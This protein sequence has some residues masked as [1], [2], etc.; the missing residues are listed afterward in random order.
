MCCED[1]SLLHEGLPQGTNALRWH[2]PLA[3]SSESWYNGGSSFP[4]L[5]SQSVRKWTGDIIFLLTVAAAVAGWMYLYPRPSN[6]PLSALQTPS[7]LQTATLLTYASSEGTKLAYRLYQPR[8]GDVDSVL[9]LLHDTLLHS[10]WYSNLGQQLAERGVAVYLPDRRG[11]GHSAGNRQDASENRDVLTDDVTALIAVAQARYP[12]KQVFLAGHGRGAGLAV[13]YVASQRPV[14]GVI[15]I[16]PYI[17]DGQPNLRPAGWR[18]LVAAHPGEA[19]LARAGLIDWRIWR[20]NWPPAMRAADPLIE[21][22][23]SIAWQQQT[24]PDDLEAAFRTLASPLLCLQGQSDPMFDAAETSEFV[25][26]FAAPDRT[27]QLM[28]GVD[29]LTIIDAAAP[30]IADWLVER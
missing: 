30:A 22:R 11:W 14:A 26:R 21:T 9:I 19:F 20:Y 3:P 15:L 10:G 1:A 29:Y 2:D 23:C 7:D 13:R 12:Q 5:E 18:A 27:L 28:P 4:S 16:S 6:G 25:A 24:V 17:A 8:S